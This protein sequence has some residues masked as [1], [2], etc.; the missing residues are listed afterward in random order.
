MGTLERITAQRLVVAWSLAYGLIATWAA[1]SH[2]GIDLLARLAAVI[3]IGGL[4]LA[5]AAHRLELS[6]A[7]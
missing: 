3:L 6:L 5:W 4:T 1:W 2:T 7:S